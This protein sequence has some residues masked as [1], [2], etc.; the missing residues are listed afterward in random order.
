MDLSIGIVGLGLIGGSIAKALMLAGQRVS[1]YDIDAKTCAAAKNDGVSI[2]STVDNI[3]ASSSIVFLATPMDCFEQYAPIFRSL[4][5]SHHVLV[6]DVGSARQPF[7]DFAKVASGNRALRFLGSH[8]M[9]GTENQGYANARGDL[10]V[11]STWIVLIEPDSGFDDFIEAMTL[12][13][14]LG[15][16]VLPIEPASHDDAV[17]R[18]SHLSHVLSGLLARS[19]GAAAA[20]S[21]ALRI[22]SGSFRDG[23]RVLSSRPAFVADLC[24]FNRDALLP[25]LRDV[26][27]DLSDLINSLSERDESEVTAFFKN[28]HE[29][30]RE[31]LGLSSRR[32]AIELIFHNPQDWRAAMLDVGR[33]GYRLASVSTADGVIK[34]RAV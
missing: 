28:A 3:V 19:A 20:N 31:F 15:A 4:A 30:R 6:I 17:A 25:V 16:L 5:P 13:V 24:L 1:G 21:L 2:A 18:V 27:A 11:G 22:A 8:P 10:F 26:A 7:N 12:I 9:A 29:I 34:L 23:T 33:R 32:G 14:R